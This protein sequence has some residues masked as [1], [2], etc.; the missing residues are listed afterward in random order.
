MNGMLKQRFRE[1]KNKNN[2]VNRF[3][4]MAKPVSFF[5]RPAPAKQSPFRFFDALLRRSNARFVFSTPCS[6]GAMP[7]LFFRRPAPTEQSPFRF[8]DAL[9]R[10]S[11]ARFIFS[12]PCSGGANRIGEIFIPN[13]FNFNQYKYKKK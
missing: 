5:R 11:K 1:A 13:F 9:L 7:V 10:Q 4:G 8:F 12:T 2:A 3:A 6:G